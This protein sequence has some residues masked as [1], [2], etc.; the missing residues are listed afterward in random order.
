[1]L[2]GLKD[3]EM[4]ISDGLQRVRPGAPVNPA[5]AAAGPPGAAQTKS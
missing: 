3:G 5:P 1:V 4:V 2:T